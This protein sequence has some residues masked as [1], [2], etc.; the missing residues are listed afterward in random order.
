[1]CLLL[2][3]VFAVVMAVCCVYW[4]VGVWEEIRNGGHSMSR[5]AETGMWHSGFVDGEGML[6]GCEVRLCECM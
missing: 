6:C 2:L 4:V 1:M 5:S 3:C